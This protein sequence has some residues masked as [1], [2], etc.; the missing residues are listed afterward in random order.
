MR[1]IYQYLVESVFKSSEFYKHAYAKDVIAKI[2]NTGH[3]RLGNTG[4][5]D[6]VIPDDILP[7]LKED[8]AKNEDN[9][10]FDTFNEIMK[11]HGLP[12][13]TKIFKGDFSGYVNGL[14]S[15]NRG[16]AFEDEFV[17]NFQTKYAQQLQDALGLKPYTFENCVPESL[18]AENQ[19]RPLT[20]DGKQI[21]VGGFHDTAGE[22]VV[23]VF[24][25]DVNGTPYNLSLKVE[26]TVTLINC[27]VTRLF[28]ERSFKEYE[29]KGKYSAETF[30][31]VD[32]NKLLD[33]FCIDHELFAKSFVNY[34][35]N[36]KLDRVDVTRDIDKRPLYD[37]I[38]SA[39]GYN[40]VLVHKI[41]PKVHYIDLRTEKDMKKII[42]IN[43]NSIKKVEVCYGR[44]NGKG[45]GVD[46]N[47]ECQN[48]KI[49][50]NI[51]NKQGGLY[52]THIMADYE[53]RH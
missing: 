37:F 11:S 26:K 19:R 2:V 51:R 21:L 25:K 45:K 29:I 48:I 52:P 3:I 47:V 44:G 20:S 10:D 7:K 50:F 53:I 5:T 28:S 39:L 46:I 17:N 9:M 31:G 41:G 36:E 33:M 22:S 40:Y 6:Y 14:A 16:N 24:V 43:P 13:W 38:C 49:K 34:G 18:G 8:F 42:G 1:N 12:V 27:G 32:G 4:E 15:K 35:K 23:D 30:N